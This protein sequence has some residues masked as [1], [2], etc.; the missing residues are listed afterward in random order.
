MIE[1][2]IAFILIGFFALFVML[3]FP[4]SVDELNQQDNTKARSTQAE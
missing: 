1:V 3:S 4:M 2:F